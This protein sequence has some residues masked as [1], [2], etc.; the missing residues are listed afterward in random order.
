MIS[1]NQNFVNADVCDSAY[2]MT[3]ETAA[4][5]AVPYE[6]A[7]PATCDGETVEIDNADSQQACEDQGKTYV[8][9]V[10]EVPAQDAT[11]PILVGYPDPGTNTANGN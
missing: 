3:I 8:P 2:D 5:A 4:Q 10:A 6:A 1:F 9:S 11:D 7:Q